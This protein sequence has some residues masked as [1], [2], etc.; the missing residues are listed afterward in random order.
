MNEAEIRADRP[1]LDS[2]ARCGGPARLAWL[3]HFGWQ[4]FGGYRDPHFRQALDQDP[5]ACRPPPS[6][7]AD[8]TRSRPVYF[9]PPV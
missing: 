9:Q 6:A 4:Y 2:R 1:A 7:P 8:V 3:S 5:A